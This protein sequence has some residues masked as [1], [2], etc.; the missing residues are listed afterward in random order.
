MT[1]LLTLGLDGA[2]WHTLDRLLAAGDLPNLSRLV[3]TGT[4][5][6]LR[7]VL[8]PVTCPAWRCSTAGKNPGKLGVYWWLNFDRSSGEL[9]SPD[10]DSFDT[11]DV[12][13]YLGEAGLRSAIVNVPMT[14][15]PP[16][17]DGLMV[18][19]FGAPF[20][21]DLDEPITYPAGEA[22]RLRAAYDWQIGIEDVT[23]S[24]G[25]QAVYDLI[26]SRFELLLDLLDDGFDYV[27]LTVFY[28]NVLQHKFG[29]GP[30]TVRAWRIVDDYLGQLPEDLVKLLYSDHGHSAI[31]GTFVINRFLAD[32]GYLTLET[33]SA[34]ALTAGAYSL[35]GRI[36][37]SPRAVGRLAKAALPERVFD[38]LVARGYPV[39][40]ADLATRVDWDASSAIALSQ[41]PIYLNQRRLG[42][43]YEAVRSQLR[44]SLLS[45]ASEGDRPLA[46][47]HQAEDVYT[48]DHLDAAPDLVV[49]AADGWEV[50]GGLTPST[51]ERQVTSWTSGNHPVGVFLA[52]GPG[53]RSTGLGPRS[54]LDVMP[55]VLRRLGCPVPTDI[56]GEAITDAF[57]GGLPDTGTRPPLEVEG[58]AE[59]RRPG[60]LEHRLQDLGYLE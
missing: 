27:H 18:A 58:S 57:V 32:E 14:Y 20:A 16:P 41:G 45:F 37:V 38:H 29:D 22:D 10:A 55:T 5:A 17:V 47:V 33:G 52:H 6:P 42:G 7:S 35:L 11:A 60:E 43:S 56:D 34:D 23:R 25:P 51:T 50:Y 40:T 48:G 9:S 8:P 53:V 44:A 1:Q 24:G 21:Y 3:E 36:G 12:W 28:L 54:L 39:S 46:D 2:A 19:G 49:E 59:Q 15:P 4:R 26:R 30:E 13:D 31:E